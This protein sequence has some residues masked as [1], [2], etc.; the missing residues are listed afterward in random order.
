MSRRRNTRTARVS[1]APG[2][3]DIE[4]SGVSPGDDDLHDELRAA[5]DNSR[6]ARA[7]RRRR[8]PS[9]ICLSTLHVHGI[10]T[11]L[12]W[13]LIARVYA[14]HFHDRHPQGLDV[15]GHL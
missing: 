5:D 15:R 14:L 8:S 10:C 3:S 7:A 9:L 12:V 4:S 11:A 2:L 13:I 1:F 6:S